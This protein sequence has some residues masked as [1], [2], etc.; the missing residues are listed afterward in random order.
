LT[1]ARNVPAVYDLPAYV[2]RVL[3]GAKADGLPVQF[4]RFEMVVALKAARTLG[5][6]GPQS[7][8]LRATEVIE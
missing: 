7:I 8:T 3:R 2:D 1:A 4:P 6:E 5:L